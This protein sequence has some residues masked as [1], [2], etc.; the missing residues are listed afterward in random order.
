MA[1]IMDPLSNYVLHVWD[2]HLRA[3]T[4]FV[5]NHMH[6]GMLLIPFTRMRIIP[7]YGFTVDLMDSQWT[8]DPCAPDCEK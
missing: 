1:C 3:P 8:L 7:L 2:I 4:S 6:N 5:T